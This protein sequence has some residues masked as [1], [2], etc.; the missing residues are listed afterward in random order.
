MPLSPMMQQ[1][2]KIK[3]EN[4]D[5]VLFFRLG[6]F[7]EMFFDDAEKV[8]KELEL[9]LTGRDCGMDNRAPMC[10]VPYHSSEGYI[11]KLINRGY[12]VAI[13]EQVEDPS[14]ATGLVKREI[15]RIVTP[16]TVLED[17]MLEEGKNNY[18]CACYVNAAGAGV[19]FCDVSTGALHAADLKGENFMDLLYNRLVAFAPKELLL[20]GDSAVFGKI[21]AFAKAK[22]DIAADVG[23]CGGV[24]IADGFES[25]AKYFA[26]EDLQP[27]LPKSE[28]MAALSLLI[29]YVELTQKTGLQR[30]SKIQ[31]FEESNF[32]KLDYSTLRNLELLE[33][34]KTGAKKG[35]LLWV[36]DK[37][38]TAM[39]KRLMRAYIEQP[40]LNVVAI[41]NRQNAVEELYG[42]TLLRLE[43][44]AEL[45]RVFDIERLSSKIC[46]GT[47]NARDLRSLCSALQRFPGVR[48]LIKNAKCKLLQEIYSEIYCF[49]EL[50]NM[51]DSA[52]VDEPPFSVREGGM[53]RQGF[54][55]E[56]DELFEIIN[57]SS[58]IIAELEAQ[59][60][61]NTGIPKLKVGYNRVFG[62]Y[63]EVSN[64][65]KNSVPEHYIRKQTLTNCERY[66][67]PRLKELEAKV[68]GAK[69]KAVALENE[70]FA[71]L[72]N[73][74]S[75]NLNKIQTTAAA[76]ARLDVF[77]SLAN[78][79]CDN[80]YVR[81]QIDLSD[82]IVI[83][84]GRHPVV[85]LLLETSLF[86]PN[87]VT[88]DQN[89][90]RVNIITGPN[91]AGKSTYM[92][93]IAI[94]VIMAQIGSF[95]PADSAKIG[96]ADAVF[97]RVGAYDD[98]SAVQST[99]MVEMSEVSH[100]LK[101]AT[102][103]SLLI[104]DEIGRGT[105]TFDGMSIA[106]AVI[107]FVCNTK[108][109]GAKAL[110]ATHYHELT[111]LEQL[112]KGIKNYNVSCKKRGDEITF[113]RRIVP[114]GADDSYGIEVAKLAGVPDWVVERA[115][116]ILKD[117][118]N[119]ENND[120]KLLKTQSLQRI[121]RSEQQGQLSLVPS[122]AHPT[123][124]RL[125]KC[126]VNTLTPIEALNLLYELKKS[127]DL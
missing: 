24:N 16:G 73:A 94:I 89:E 55:P 67:T 3:N 109:L 120:I 102:R 26:K 42:D 96:V 62:Y 113:L 83:S 53:V 79:A 72:C 51:I 5:C 1:Y 12:K 127:A 48:E 10:G 125:R 56:L 33:T 99:F 13:C 110:F 6:D 76:V 117:L 32:L 116:M 66:F 90:N 27:L 21:A 2:F 17:S 7:Y 25:L 54:S 59:E 36:L 39:G 69:D 15:V 85:E 68:L 103:R 119:D 40:L 107:E 63:I 78:T 65:Y 114:G 45:S 30:I 81:P 91:M 57:D 47:G 18:I 20:G 88:L 19:C 115:K 80:N 38:K 70:I 105:S 111:V 126:D 50:M 106:R 87:D 14:T 124:E 58:G 101:K 118:E 8:S 34:L 97:T 43:L 71:S 92:R 95:V 9:T 41:T 93:Q 52:L 98:L 75:D 28:L 31:Y 86:V 112:H 4:K 61:E 122:T 11:S 29:A 84:G 121:N 64:S 74:V 35:S 46:Y 44:D 37:T 60:R 49:D 82:E 77:N 123:V 22:L 100:I 23:F 108:K 104:F